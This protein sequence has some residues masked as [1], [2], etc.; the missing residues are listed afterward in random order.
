MNNVISFSDFQQMGRDGV[1]TGQGS[2]GAYTRLPVVHQLE[3][4]SELTPREYIEK[5]AMRLFD[6]AT[7][8]KMPFLAYLLIMAVDEARGK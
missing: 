1:A 7:E 8:H 4:A 5:V 3:A 6:I 2:V